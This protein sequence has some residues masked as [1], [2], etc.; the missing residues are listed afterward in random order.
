MI[1][2]GCVV[3]SMLFP[4]R[5]ARLSDARLPFPV[6]SE[7]LRGHDRRLVEQPGPV[8]GVKLDDLELVC[9]ARA[10]RRGLRG[11]VQGPAGADV[12]LEPLRSERRDVLEQHHPHRPVALCPLEPLTRDLLAVLARGLPVALA[13]RGVANRLDV[14][15][16]RHRRGE[17]PY[18]FSAYRSLRVP[19]VDELVL[20]TDV[21]ELVDHRA[22][23]LDVL[24]VQ[25]GVQTVQVLSWKA[26]S[27]HAVSAA[28]RTSSG[29]KGLTP[30]MARSSGK[31]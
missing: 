9:G 5:F 21:A 29:W 27:R 14:H 13:E 11:D 31:P 25:V 24:R 1:F 19:R 3:N 26:F 10:L 15:Q 7:L 28:S 16:R 17:P 4:E 30:S 23:Y 2:C 12:H 22:H 18:R 8:A 20:G 6:I